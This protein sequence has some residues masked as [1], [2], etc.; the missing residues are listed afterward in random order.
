MSFASSSRYSAELHSRFHLKARH[1]NVLVFVL[2]GL[3]VLVCAE[4]AAT[5]DMAAKRQKKSES[6]ML[7]MKFSLSAM[8]WFHPLICGDERN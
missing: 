1:F 8:M 4:A 5:G 6:L 2:M 7:R 3:S